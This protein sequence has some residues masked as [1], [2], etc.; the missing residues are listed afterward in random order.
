ML[1]NGWSDTKNQKPGHSLVH[2]VIIGILDKYSC[3]GSTFLL[4]ALVFNFVVFVI[5]IDTDVNIRQAIDIFSLVYQGALLLSLTLLLLLKYINKKTEGLKTVQKSCAFLFMF[6]PILVLPLVAITSTDASRSPSEPFFDVGV[7]RS[8][9]LGLAVPITALKAA[10][11]YNIFPESDQLSSHRESLSLY[12]AYEVALSILFTYLYVNRYDSST[13]VIFA[14]TQKVGLLYYLLGVFRLYDLETEA[15]VKGFYIMRN[16]IELTKHIVMLYDQEYCSFFTTLSAGLTLWMGVLFIRRY[17]RLDIFDPKAKADTLDYLRAVLACI[18]IGRFEH[19]TT[20]DRYY[21]NRFISHRMNCRDHGCLCKLSKPSHDDSNFKDFLVELAKAKIEG[22]DLTAKEV[23]AYVAVIVKRNKSITSMNDILLQYLKAAKPSWAT[24]LYTSY[25]EEHVQR[26]LA[27][28][29]SALVKIKKNLKYNVNKDELARE[30]YNE[31]VLIHK[32][33]WFKR[34]YDSALEEINSYLQEAKTFLVDI[35]YSRTGPKEFYDRMR[36]FHLIDGR[37]KAVYDRFEEFNNSFHT[38]HLLLYYVYYTNLNY[39]VIKSFELRNTLLNFTAFKYKGDVDYYEISNEFLFENSVSIVAYINAKEIGNVKMVYGDIRT[40]FDMDEAEMIG[41]NVMHF[42]PEIIAVNHS[43]IMKGYPYEIEKYILHRYIDSYLCGKSKLVLPLKGV[44]KYLPIYSV[45]NG[46]LLCTYWKQQRYDDSHYIFLDDENRVKHYSKSLLRHINI[47]SID[48]DIPIHNITKDFEQHLPMI[49]DEKQKYIESVLPEVSHRFKKFIIPNLEFA[50]SFAFYNPTTGVNTTIDFYVRVQLIFAV[51]EK[52]EYDMNTILILNNNPNSRRRSELSEMDGMPSAVVEHDQQ[53]NDGPK[54]ISDNV[55]TSKYLSFKTTTKHIAA[56]PEDEAAKIKAEYSRKQK[57]LALNEMQ[58]YRKKHRKMKKDYMS[59]SR[60]ID[61]D[62]ENQ[63]RS[64]SL[65]TRSS[66]DYLKKAQ[67]QFSSKFDAFRFNKLKLAFLALISVVAML[68]VFKTIWLNTGH[69]YAMKVYMAS[70]MQVLCVI[71]QIVQVKV[72][73]PFLSDA[74]F[75]RKTNYQPIEGL[76]YYTDFAVS[77]L[78]EQLKEIKSDEE[79]IFIDLKKNNDI[80]KE[81]SELQSFIVSGTLS[82]PED[83]IFYQSYLK[84]GYEASKDDLAFYSLLIDKVRQL[85]GIVQNVDEVTMARSQQ[86][87]LRKKFIFYFE[88]LVVFLLL[89]LNVVLVVSKLWNVVFNLSS[90]NLVRNNQLENRHQELCE[91]ESFVK[92]CCDYNEDYASKVNRLVDGVSCIYNK[93]DIYRVDNEAK[94]TWKVAS[95][96]FL[97]NIALF[98]VIGTVVLLSVVSKVGIF[99]LHSELDHKL[100]Y[101]DLINSVFKFG[102]Q[103]SL[104]TN[105]SVLDQLLQKDDKD[106]AD[107]LQQFTP[108][109]IALNDRDLSRNMVRFRSVCDPES[110]TF[111]R[112]YDS[113]RRINFCTDDISRAV[114]GMSEYRYYNHVQ[115]IIRKLNSTKIQE[116]EYNGLWTRTV[117]NLIYTQA[118]LYTRY[119]S[120]IST[121]DQTSGISQLLFAKISS[122]VLYVFLFLFTYLSYR[123]LLSKEQISLLAYNLYGKYYLEHNAFLKLH[124]MTSYGLKSDNWIVNGF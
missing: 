83:S 97:C 60:L 117:L 15:L 27:E 87:E 86:T 56:E 102:I 26:I 14:I 72:Y 59:K 9:N 35:V 5:M 113:T 32:V 41:K 8:V 93:P 11:F 17:N 57:L 46:I 73:Q 7:L 71:T 24:T 20:S 111:N 99:H 28:K 90:L 89:A 13:L 51:K 52:G 96:R 100:Q 88:W 70:S 21:I 103:N 123:A 37:L 65:S 120:F 67:E 98:Y 118:A 116:D 106:E 85:Y 58:L 45:S 54:F 47:Q 30:Q 101:S 95:L 34:L 61:N 91:T 4:V 39:D 122:I 38:R 107:N 124:Y 2:K 112:L 12:T 40:V 55:E 82:T 84:P 66:S 94:F 75:K 50:S 121:M 33:F 81:L 6:Y 80:K 23:A 110:E 108:L 92:V 69:F 18:D 77:T 42:M 25:I 43:D 79:R 53:Y 114:R 49:E 64:M 109:D 115:D 31:T 119:Q 76:R 74:E 19:I 48:Y 36:V 1:K 62:Q 16:T 104:L 10:V 22:A 78:N 63:Q 68:E 3:F 29:S 105:S 44:F